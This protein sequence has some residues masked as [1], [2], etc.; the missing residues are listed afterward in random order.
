MNKY[1]KLTSLVI[2]FVT[3]CA[4]NTKTATSST[5]TP[6][7]SPTL[8][9]SYD[10][11]N[12]HR[13]SSSTLGISFSIPKGWQVNDNRIGITI[14]SDSDIQVEDNLSFDKGDAIIWIRLISQEDNLT[15]DDATIIDMLINLPPYLPPRK[16]APHIIQVNGKRFAFA[17][18]GINRPVPY[19]SFSAILPLDEK[20]VLGLI[21]TSITNER[22]FRDIFQVIISSIES[23]KKQ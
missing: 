17:G 19:P 18:Y 9:T 2:I 1:A 4:P 20:A 13:Y 5:L 11:P 12:W 6:S 3:S 14:T 8:T 23:N 21:F 22:S 15:I 10:N 7:P 16:E